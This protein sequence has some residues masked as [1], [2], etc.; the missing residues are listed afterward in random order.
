MNWYLV[1]FS[2]WKWKVP[3]EEVMFTVNELNW[4]AKMKMN[5]NRNWPRIISSYAHLPFGFKSWKIRC[6]NAENKLINHATYYGMKQPKTHDFG[7]IWKT[8]VLFDDEKLLFA[9]Q[10]RIADAKHWLRMWRDRHAHFIT[11]YV[12]M[13]NCQSSE[14]GKTIES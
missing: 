9:Q 8:G 14:N 5:K 2:D 7:L 6:W 10:Q 3:K 1:K 11:R 13:E 12:S 4:N